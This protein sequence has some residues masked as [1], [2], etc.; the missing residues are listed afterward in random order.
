MSAFI[1]EGRINDHFIERSGINYHPAHI[2]EKL[3]SPGWYMLGVNPDHFSKVGHKI[4]RKD[5]CS[6][7]NVNR[8]EKHVF[9]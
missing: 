5:T 6:G 8:P 7:K 4:I 3:L 1:I 9:W 2:H